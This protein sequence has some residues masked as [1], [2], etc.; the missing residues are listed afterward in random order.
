VQVWSDVLD[1]AT[2]NMLRFEGTAADA[3]TAGGVLTLN[4]GANAPTYTTGS[5]GR[6]GEG[7]AFDGNDRART[8]TGG[9]DSM[10]SITIDA[11]VKRNGAPSA[12][13]QLASVED[14]TRR[15]M[16]IDLS[17]DGSVSGGYTDSTGTEQSTAWTPSGTLW[18]GSWHHVA[19]TFTPAGSGVAI[20]SYIDGVLTSTEVYPNTFAATAGS[21]LYIGNGSVLGGG[22]LKATIDE[23]RVSS[24]A[25]STD[26]LVGYVR[27][28]RKHGELIWD[29]GTVASCSTCP[30][31]SN[32][33]TSDV[34]YAGPA[35]IL[36]DNARY[37]VTTQQRTSAAGA[38]AS[39]WSAW[40]EPDWF[41]ARTAASI[42]V[43]TGAAV[44]LGAVLPG[45]DAVGTST[46]DVSTTGG[47]GY[48]LYARG[49]SDTWTLTS[50]TY[51]IARWTGA[52]TPTTWAS[53]AP[54]AGYF[55][56]TVLSAT[57]GKDTAT[58]GVGTVP[59]DVSNLKYGGLK[60]T[61]DL[62]LHSRTTYAATTDTIS[63]G[64]RA[65]PSMATPPGSYAGTVTVV[66]VANP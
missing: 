21:Q 41:E 61:I 51:G 8:T 3:G 17:S 56:L 55:G 65:N 22:N 10:T 1:G 64:W 66:A 60:K 18:N 2:R 6:F 53:G 32:A 5:G 50:G 43:T 13:A 36:L 24:R 38:P 28:S 39:T 23:V 25:L 7:L 57:G 42:S 33:R 30:T 15:R 35:G 49:E 12:N 19:A 48:T 31:A 4:G 40:S 29:S 46:V 62:A 37:W 20:R 26:E 11:W 58:W 44:A 59:S 16:F 27:T 9:F 52:P 63:I 47:D 54:G 45:S 34:T 14:G